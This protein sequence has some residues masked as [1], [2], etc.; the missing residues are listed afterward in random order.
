MNQVDF[1]TE[2][3]KLPLVERVQIIE[4]LVQEIKAELQ[5]TPAPSLAERR[6][7]MMAAASALR[8]DY[9][10]NADLTAFTALDAE[11]FHGKG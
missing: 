5:L 3:R 1:I 9:L 2:L 4:T 7:Q 10:T 6:R 8:Q 11:D